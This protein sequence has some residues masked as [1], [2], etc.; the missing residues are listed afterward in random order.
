[1]SDA[2]ADDGEKLATISR[3]P[4][5]ELRIRWKSFK[6][7]TYLDLREWSANPHSGV[8]WPTKKGVT[9]KRRELAD[10]MKA[11]EAARKLS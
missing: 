4:G 2:L 9:V 6:G 1:M 5:R 8:F 3:G 7:L 11:L 10:V